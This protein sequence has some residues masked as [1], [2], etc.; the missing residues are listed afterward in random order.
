MQACIA[1]CAEGCRCP[2][3]QPPRGLQ[4]DLHVGN[5]VADCLVLA[6]QLAE[7]L[8]GARVPH[9]ALEQALHGA[10]MASPRSEEHTSELQSLMRSSYADF[11]LKKK[12]HNNEKKNY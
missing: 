10:D 5:L 8:S 6:D 2:V 9:R 4:S 3:D 11:C 12:K 1:R 7:L